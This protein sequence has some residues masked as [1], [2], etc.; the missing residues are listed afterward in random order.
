MYIRQFKAR[1]VRSPLSSICLL[2]FFAVSG[3]PTTAQQAVPADSSADPIAGLPPAPD[4]AAEVAAEVAAVNDSPPVEEAGSGEA[5]STPSPRITAP[6]IAPAPFEESPVPVAPPST[7]L[8]TVS[9]PV[10]TATENVPLREIVKARGLALPLAEASIVIDKSERRLDLLS[11]GV[12]VKSYR[13]ALGRNPVGAKTAQGDSRTPEGHFY[14]CTRNA[15]TSAFHIFLGLSYPGLPDAKRAVNNKKITWRDYQII[16]RRLA[17]R[18]RPPWETK[19]GG[20]IGIHGGTDAPYA[21]KQ[22]RQR[23]GK[24]WTAGCIALTN[25]EIEEIHAATQMGTPVEI[26]P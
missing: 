2:C 10:A 25:R 8:A 23:G 21:Q 24:D 13:V 20:W 11:R 17:S 7:P 14:I 12:L 6:I 15:K 18:G 16:N 1:S 5:T 22:M 3:V 4:S 26:K 19:L 9:V